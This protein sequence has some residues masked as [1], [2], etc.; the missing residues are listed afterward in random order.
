MFANK[1]DVLYKCIANRKGSRF[2]GFLFIFSFEKNFTVP[3][4]TTKWKC[5]SKLS[6]F[7]AIN[8]FSEQLLEFGNKNDI[9]IL[10]FYSFTCF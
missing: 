6:F 9:I 3:P 5:S 10:S 2:G 4:Q 7:N 1:S 8:V